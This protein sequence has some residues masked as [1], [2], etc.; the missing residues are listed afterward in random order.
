MDTSFPEG[1]GVFLKYAVYLKSIFF[2][3]FGSFQQRK[4][5]IDGILV[6]KLI[7]YLFDFPFIA[8]LLLTPP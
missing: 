5:F 4:S 7:F 2:F 6:G 8:F 3:C 1:P